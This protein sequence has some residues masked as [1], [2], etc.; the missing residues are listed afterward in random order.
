M[1]DGKIIIK[2]DGTPWGTS[3][4]DEKGKPIARVTGV[5]IFIPKPGALPR[6]IIEVIMPEVEVKLDPKQVD[7]REYCHWCLRKKEDAE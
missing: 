6:A 3:V 5:Q 2:S 1:S 7:I 4:T